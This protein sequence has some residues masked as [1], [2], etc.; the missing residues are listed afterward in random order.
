MAAT[1]R[2]STYHVPADG[3]WFE[4]GE[5]VRWTGLRLKYRS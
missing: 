2:F 5:I 1:S 4:P 3:I